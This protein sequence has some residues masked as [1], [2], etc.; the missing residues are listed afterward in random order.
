MKVELRKVAGCNQ[1]NKIFLKIST[2]Y[3]QLR[4]LSC[5][6]RPAFGLASVSYQES[7]FLEV[8]ETLRTSGAPA[9]VL[10]L[11][12]IFFS[13]SRLRFL[14]VYCITHEC[15]FDFLGVCLPARFLRP[16]Y[17]APLR[18]LPFFL[19][20]GALH[21]PLASSL[22]RPLSHLSIIQ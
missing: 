2:A 14:C 3:A 16:C 15:F 9:G 7:A 11:V 19:E 1:Q 12:F 21:A 5:A 20:N 22:H 6:F 4:E 17:P 18:G 10:R 8:R 13:C